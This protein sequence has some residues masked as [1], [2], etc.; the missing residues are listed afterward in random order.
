[1]RQGQLIV[2]F[3]R[4]FRSLLRRFYGRLPPMKFTKAVLLLVAF[5]SILL[6]PRSVVVVVVRGVLRHSRNNFFEKIIHHTV[7]Y[8]V[9]RDL[10]L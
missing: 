5:C 6:P 1:M 4:F 7:D 3:L 10:Y 8:V 2:G 9:V